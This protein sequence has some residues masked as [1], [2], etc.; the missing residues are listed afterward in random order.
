MKDVQHL[1][2]K[3]T[4]AYFDSPDP[5]T[6]RNFTNEMLQT[7][8]GYQQTAPGYLSLE[9]QYRLPYGQLNLQQQQQ[10]LYGYDDADGVHHPGTL[11]LGRSGTEYTRAGDI[12]D[13]TKYGPASTQAFLAANPYLALGLGSLTGRLGD[14]PLLTQINSQAREG[15]VPPQADLNSILDMLNSQ[16]REGLA[17]GGKLSPQ[18]ARALTQSSR[19]AFSDRGNVYGNQA[20]AAELL[21][22]DA[23]VRQRQQQAQQL[24]S[25]VQSMN[26]ANAA[27]GLADRT[28][29]QQFALGVQGANQSQNDFTGRASQI[30]GTQLS[31]PFQAIL[32]RASGSAGSSGGL[33]PQQLIGQGATIFDASNPYAQ[34]IYSSNFNAESANNIAKA[35][36]NNAQTSSYLALAGTILG[37]LL[38]DKRIKKNVKKTGDRTK[39]G[40][41]I[42]EGEYKTD[43]KKKRYRFVL[44]QDVE[45]VRPDAVVT[46][47]LSGLKAVKYQEID[48]P[49][50]EI[51]GKGKR[52]RYFNMITG[53]LEEAA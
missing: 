11:E 29:R 30:F 51:R 24:A 52:A 31:D 41:P 34:D 26:L 2:L 23:A 6:P 5:A 20:I 35:N 18:D 17:S 40:I 38:S 7:L 13:V 19:G 15:L 48:A 8:K 16:A 14:S 4:R 45:K 22:R 25:G 37:G 42:V 44:A 50:Q 10:A 27:Q 28:Q 53:Q 49:F 36:A 21:S 39:D 3:H 46:D 32:G 12:A 47:E 43:D 1:L 33:A 9:Q